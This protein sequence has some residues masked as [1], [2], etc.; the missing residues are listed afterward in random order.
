[1]GK[2]LEFT[3]QEERKV[4]NAIMTINGILLE[5]ME[6]GVDSPTLGGL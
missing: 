5:K 3:A 1:M 6:D 4:S 2:Q